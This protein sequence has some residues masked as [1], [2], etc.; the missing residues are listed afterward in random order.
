VIVS[1]STG[2][3]D[4]EKTLNGTGLLGG[5]FGLL[6]VNGSTLTTTIYYK[7]NDGSNDALQSISVQLEYYDSESSISGGLLSGVVLKLDNLLSGN[8]ISTSANPRP[9]L[10]IITRRN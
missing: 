1:T 5:A 2:I 10:V 7:L 9:P 6:P 8:L 4:L 3:I